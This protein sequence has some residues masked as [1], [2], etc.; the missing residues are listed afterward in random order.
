MYETDPGP[1]KPHSKNFSKN[2]DEIKYEISFTPGKVVIKHFNFS[3]F[4]QRQSYYLNK[5]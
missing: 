4:I 5:L 2:I 1:L 3:N